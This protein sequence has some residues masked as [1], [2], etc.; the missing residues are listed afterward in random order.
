[1]SE[2]T[3]AAVPAALPA[4]ASAGAVL[5]LAR[6][7][8]G[9]PLEALAALVKVTPARLKALESDNYEQLLDLT[10]AR[11]LARA[12][13]RVLKIDAEPVVALIPSGAAGRLERV[14]E[15]LNTPMPD[16]GGGLSLGEWMPWQRPVPWLVL[17]LLVGAAVFMLLPVTR[18]T[19]MV[20][21]DAILPPASATVIEMP[22]DNLTPPNPVPAPTTAPEVVQAPASAAAALPAVTSAA[23]APTT[24]SAPASDTPLQL[25]ASEETWVQV[26]DANARVLLSRL[27]PAGETVSI[28]GALPLRVRIGNVRGTQ[29][30][31][32]GQPVDLGSGRRDNV[33]TLTLQ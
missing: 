26:S 30:E 6:E 3:S 16:S 18:S 25:R 27:I 19:D 24:A 9:M 28:G 29:V 20:A 11:G 31:F 14:G 23:S 17:A 33:L 15:G 5:R 22:A 1:M 7:R 12:C 21:A 10:F 13:C 2:T 4:G 8:Q 32:R